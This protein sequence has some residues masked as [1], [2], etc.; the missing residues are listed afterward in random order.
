MH[1]V[2]EVHLEA[3]ARRGVLHVVEQLARVIDLGARGRVDFDEIGEA[4][5][6][7]L[8]AAGAHAARL[9]SDPALAVE[10][11]G[12]DARDGGLAHAARPGEEEC[13]VH[14][15]AGERVHQRAPHVLLPDEL[16]ELLRAP[17]ARQGGVAHRVLDKHPDADKQAMEAARTSL[18]SGTRHRRCRCCL[19]AL[20]GF[21]TGRRGETD[22][23]HH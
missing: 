18:S 19:P 20:T 14:A 4:S 9:G 12:E 1:F 17:L 21:T 8:E 2:D 5:R 10:A 7:D 3:T 16:G 6:V 23:G 15:A 22:A 11:L 13:V